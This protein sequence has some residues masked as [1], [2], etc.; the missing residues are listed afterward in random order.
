MRRVL[1]VASRELAYTAH[2][3]VLGSSTGQQSS[4]EQRTF[5]DREMQSKENQISRHG[6]PLR[7]MPS[8]QLLVIR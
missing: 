4:N 3:H 2:I 7:I 1:S 8:C 5:T 6:E